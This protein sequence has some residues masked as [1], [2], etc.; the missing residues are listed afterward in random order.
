MGDLGVILITLGYGDE[1]FEM[2]VEGRHRLAAHPRRGRSR[3]HGAGL[4]L[5]R[6]QLIVGP[7][8]FGVGDQRIAFATA[9]LSGLIDSMVPA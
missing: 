2:A 5:Q 1:L 4:P 7:V 8:V 3:Q 9:S 6:H